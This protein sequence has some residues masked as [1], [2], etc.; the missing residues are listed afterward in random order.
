M[1]QYKL[2]YFNGRAVGEPIRFIFAA[3]GVKYEDHRIDIAGEWEGVKSSCGYGQLPILYIDGVQLT[4]S[5]A[6]GRYLG[7]LFDFV[8]ADPMMAARVDELVETLAEIRL[9]FRDFIMEHLMGDKTKAA[10]LKKNLVENACPKYYATFVDI[11]GRTGTSGPFATG[12]KPT[13][14]DFFVAS[15]L[16]VWEELVV[17]PEF[18]KKYPKL[19]A[20][21]KAVF[22]I[23]SVAEY[24]A[25]RPVT[26]F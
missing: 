22:S 21:R 25:K 6:I 3:A 2:T 8:P 15:W 17:G 13:W 14:V 18:I 12:A 16:E 5:F 24:V 20:L 11:I 26:P 23:P 7:K 19:E 10:E 4:Q 1:P 9:Q